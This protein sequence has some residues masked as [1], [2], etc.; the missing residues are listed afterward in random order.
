VRQGGDSFLDRDGGSVLQLM[1][2]SIHQN[3]K[4]LSEID[5]AVGDGDHGINMDK[6]VLKCAERLQGNPAGF[7][8]GLSTL[9]DVLLSEIGGSIGPLYGTF[10]HE[11]A[12][13]G[14]GESRIGAEV[15]GRMLGRATAALRELSGAELGDKT[16][17]DALLP[18]VS[19]YTRTAAS[20][21]GF[22]AALRAMSDA[23]E[24]GKE[25][26][27]NMVAKVGRSSRLGERSRGVLDAGASSCA[28]LLAS[29]AEGIAAIVSKAS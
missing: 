10:F 14:K 12:E 20:G 27:R 2:Q 16:M 11:M 26:T 18:A 8:Q 1:I 7:V 23:A 5:G 24:Q 29:M 19:A 13:A 28:L 17:M 25:S 9:G 4:H 21:A 22:F 3:A 6:G 15:L